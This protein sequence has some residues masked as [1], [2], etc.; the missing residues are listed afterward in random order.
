[1]LGPALSP[2]QAQAL[3]ASS[4]PALHGQRERTVLDP[5]VRHTGEIAADRVAL[6]WAAGALQSLQTQVAQALGLH[7]VEAHLHNLLVYATGQF[8]KPHQDTE[9]HDGMVAT[10]VVLWPCAH[11]GGELQVWRGD[12]VQ[13]FASQHL[14]AQ[15][16][17][18]CAF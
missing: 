6:H 15:A 1:M 7:A 10:L 13:L 4:T 16:L 18:W 8:F 9:K 17:R 3:H 2:E 5:R 14:Q 12:S 11:I